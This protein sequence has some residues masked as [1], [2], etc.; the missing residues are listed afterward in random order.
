MDWN[1]KGR[2]KLKLAILK[3]QEHYTLDE[4]L[5]WGRI[6]GVEKDY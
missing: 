4:V 2:I 1:Y 3:I 5:F 6:E